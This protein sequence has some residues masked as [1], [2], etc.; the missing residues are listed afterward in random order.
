MKLK[1]TTSPFLRLFFILA[2]LALSGCQAAR[3]AVPPGLEGHS[4]FLVCEGRNDFKLSETFSFGPY[5]VYDVHRGWSNRFT[6]GIV[7]FQKS[8]ARQKLEYSLRTP[9]GTVWRAQAVTGVVQ[10]D[11]MGQVIGGDLTWGIGHKTSY[12]VRMGS[13]GSETPWT[14]NV[15][16]GNSDTVLKGVFANG[17]TTYRVTGSHRL[18]G[19]S[20]PLVDPTGYI[21]SRRSRPVMAV[22]VLNAGSVHFAS[23]LSPADREPLAAVAVALLLYKDL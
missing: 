4:D 2:A 8:S 20:I 9:N 12:V 16:E 3:M 17:T 19:S 14:L 10:K 6:W 23:D 5:E 18:A 22:D 13:D 11:V 1:Y 21:V 7:F 15:A